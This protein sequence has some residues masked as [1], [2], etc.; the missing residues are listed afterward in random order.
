MALEKINCEC[1]NR[2]GCKYEYYI[3]LVHKNDYYETTL[4][5]RCIEGIYTVENVADIYAENDDS[6]TYVDLKYMETE[7]RYKLIK[8]RLQKGLIIGLVYHHIF[9]EWHREYHTYD[10][11]KVLSIRKEKIERTTEEEIH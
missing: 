2:Y 3:N 4:D 1:R 9:Y 7:E 8:E 11:Y 10:H 6:T 5:D